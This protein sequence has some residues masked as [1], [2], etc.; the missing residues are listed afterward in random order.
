M[1]QEIRHW[2]LT[3]EEASGN[4]VGENHGVGQVGVEFW[5]FGQLLRGGTWWDGAVEVRAT[6]ISYIYLMVLFIYVNFILDLFLE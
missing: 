1:G 5:G 2:V 6:Y 3:W 4:T